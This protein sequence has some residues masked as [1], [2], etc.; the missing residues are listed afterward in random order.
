MHCTTLF[1][2]LLDDDAV[3]ENQ[4]I[5]DKRIMVTSDDED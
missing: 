1:A 4:K 3:R 2:C 5:D